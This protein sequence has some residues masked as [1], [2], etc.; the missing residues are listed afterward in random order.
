MLRDG[1]GVDV[2]EVRCGS[3]VFVVRVRSASVA[4]A[5]GAA[6]SALSAATGG[7]SVPTTQR[8]ALQIMF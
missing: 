8:W 4:A 6:A 2:A 3:I 1:D 7:L 5:A